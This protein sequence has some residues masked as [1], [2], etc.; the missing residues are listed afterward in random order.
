[1]AKAEIHDPHVKAIFAELA[2]DRLILRALIE[3][4]LP[5][6]Q[7][8]AWKEIEAIVARI[9]ALGGKSAIGG[10]TPESS[11]QLIQA[12]TKTAVDFVRA[13]GPKRTRQ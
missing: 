7:R 5:G 6:D 11:Q 3:A 4:M 13:I 10:A 8:E 2:A 9:E 12:A 1:M